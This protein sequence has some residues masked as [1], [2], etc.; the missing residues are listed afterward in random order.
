MIVYDL[1]GRAVRHLFQGTVN[2]GP[3]RVDWNGRDDSGRH[4]AT[5]VYL[6]RVQVAQEQQIVK[7]TLAK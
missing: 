3:Q 1:G 6:A 4:L 2:P 7:M 5:G